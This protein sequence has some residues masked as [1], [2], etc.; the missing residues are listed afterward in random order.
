L[1]RYDRGGSV[2]FA[3]AHEEIIVF[4]TGEGRCEVVRTPGTW[5]GGRR[6]IRRGTVEGSLRLAPGDVMLL[7]TDGVTEIRD[8]RGEQFGLERLC[9]ELERVQG[10]P[11]QQIVN[12]LV[13][14]VGA[15]GDADDDV[16]L[17]VFRY[18][19]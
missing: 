4:R 15:W 16:S 6:D 19:R 11:P 18:E 12:H 3:G 10:E 1:L 8:A 17:V 2:V 13:Q 9:A 7:H 14:T 5:V